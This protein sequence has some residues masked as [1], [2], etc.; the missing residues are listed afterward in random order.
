M[1][2]L[3]GKVALITGASRGIGRA[4][5]VAFAKKGAK[6]IVN[7]ASRQAEAEETER[8]IIS[9]GGLKPLLLKFD[10][11]I[12]DE[13][14]AAIK[15]IE[16]NWG[17]VEILVNNAGISKDNLLVRMKAV[18]WSSV[19]AT[20]LDG[21]F[22]C[23]KACVKNM[24]RNRFG[25]IINISSVVGE[26]GSAGQVAYSAAKAGLIGMTKSLALELASREITVNAVAPGY[27]ETDM[28][29]SF[30]EKY[31][32]ELLKQIPLNSSGTPE[33]VANAVCFLAS[34]E[35]RYI[36]GHVLAVNGGMYI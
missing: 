3:A 31:Q 35:A 19:L 13:V 29:S 17:S 8:Q 7:F 5:A 22:Y 25:R 9:V 10:V 6:V 11:A 23:S 20:N 30:S 27:I 28:T 15:V 4:I 26:K 21:A 12:E 2:S 1:N 36:T 32:E 33:D 16:N 24:M 18:D 14:L 34:G